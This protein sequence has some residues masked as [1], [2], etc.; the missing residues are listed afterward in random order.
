[1]HEGDDTGLL[2]VEDEQDLYDKTQRWQSR[3]KIEDHIQ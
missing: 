1:M 2:L 3:N